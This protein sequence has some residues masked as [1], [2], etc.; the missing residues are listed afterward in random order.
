MDSGWP[1]LSE[2]GPLYLSPP[3]EPRASGGCGPGPAEP[4]L[5]PPR[6]SQPP[7]LWGSA[8][9]MFAKFEEESVTYSAIV[10]V[11]NFSSY[12][13]ALSRIRKSP[14]KTDYKIGGSRISV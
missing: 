9:S 2:N 4:P 6:G 3:A 1:V 14:N 12:G 13:S 11:E 10:E 5:S 7:P 8:P